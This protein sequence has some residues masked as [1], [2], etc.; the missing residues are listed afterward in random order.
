[1][2]LSHYRA[3]QKAEG[4]LGTLRL[5]HCPCRNSRPLYIIPLSPRLPLGD[6]GLMANGLMINV[7]DRQS[8]LKPAVAG[9][10]LSGYIYHIPSALALLASRLASALPLL[11]AWARD[12]IQTLF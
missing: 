7:L 5:T 1:M 2:P 10:N 11:Q 6:N 8:N 9:K 12:I 4:G 3:V